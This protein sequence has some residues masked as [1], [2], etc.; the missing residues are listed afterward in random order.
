MIQ[1]IQVCSSI[2]DV[3]KE[4]EIEMKNK[5]LFIL[6]GIAFIWGLLIY[7][8][9]YDVHWLK[10]LYFT[11]SLFFVNLTTA[12]D[13]GLNIETQ[14]WQNIYIPGI[15]AVLVLVWAVAS[16]YIRL[17]KDSIERLG[18][19]YSGGNIVVIGLGEGNRAYI[20]SEL[21]ESK[22]KI[23]VIELDKNN[24]YIEQYRNKTWVEIADASQM[25]ILKD[26]RVAYKE[27]I[28]I[29]TGSDINNINIAKQIL[30][31]NIEAKIFLQLN[32]RSLRNFHKKDGVLSENNIKVFSYYEESARELFDAHDIDGEDS[33]IIQS[34]DP[35]SIVVV[36]DTILAHEV[37]AQACI[38]GQLPNA[39][40]LTIYCIDKDINSFQSAMEVE[41]PSIVDVPNVNLVYK[42]ADTAS[43][44][45]Y[46]LDIWQEPNLT[47]IILCDENGQNNLDVAANLTNI[48]YLEKSVDKTL[49]CKIHIAMSDSTV[50]GDQ[51]DKNSNLFDHMHIFAQT[52][53]LS[54]KKFIIAKSRD[55]QAIATNSIYNT[56]GATVTN[57]D[58]Y[59][60]TFSLYEG[61]YNNN[62]YMNLT[63]EDWD[64]LHYFFKE[65]NR[66]VADHMK[67]KLKYLGLTTQKSEL[68]KNN[69]FLK[70]KEIFET[71]LQNHLVQLAKCE[72]YRWMAFHYLQGYKP[73]EFISKKEKEKRKQELE[74]K[75]LHMCLVPFDEFKT[76]SNKL[77]A[78]DYPKGYF[79]GFDIMIVKHIPQILTYAGY[80]LVELDNA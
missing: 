79:E 68:H 56:I 65:S 18:N 29:S 12:S 27:H 7:L 28:V 71:K 38:M 76:R 51:I 19:V 50:L 35:Y 39:N 1:Q 3:E 77:E 61:N 33:K 45:F 17:V 47:H 58:S 67:T 59:Q 14:W 26:L 37:V 44:E 66:A 30:N 73:M 36:G 31:L 72:H 49:A 62:L 41:F 6:V 74:N 78:L 48:Q 40:R 34:N 42:K 69:L 24:P 25:Q 8:F 22:K 60:Y 80:K 13:L 16:L 63:R 46:K 52:Q 32:D 54:N 43:M 9:V 70:N 11:L 4:R 55:D 2:M 20:E 57:Y 75:K 64:K 23:I 10:A 5:F 53:E 21:K 15:L